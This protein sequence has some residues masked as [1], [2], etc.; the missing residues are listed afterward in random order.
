MIPY[1][2]SLRAR[3]VPYVNYALIAINVLV[4]LY[5]ISLSGDTVF[6]GNR[7]FDALDRWVSSW[8]TVACRISDTCPVAFDRMLGDPPNPWVTLLT[9]TFIHAGWLHLIFNMLF[10][11]IFGDNVEDAMG[12]LPYL[13][14]YL[15][16]GLIASLAQVASGPSSTVPGV[17][18]SGAI[19]GVM[20]AYLVLY[21]GA[22]VHVIIPIII[23]PWFTNLPAW[24]LMVFWFGMQ[25]ISGF[26]ALCARATGGEGGVAW[27][28]HIGGFL[29]GLLLVWF[30]R[31]RRRSYDIQH[32]YDRFGWG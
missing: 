32:Q 18:A 6:V 25:V 7:P 11:W 17:G 5:E 22:T 30:F 12:H 19:A 10:L 3:S 28:A 15:L 16:V 1:S 2:D 4:F 21:P 8:G 29:A 20:A 26:A 27:W 24:I 23:I 13:V 31:S 9:A 14:F